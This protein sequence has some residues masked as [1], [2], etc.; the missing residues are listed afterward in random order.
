MVGAPLGI[1]GLGLI[2]TSLARRC[3]FGWN[4]NVLYHDVRRNEQAESELNAACVDV[5]TLLARRDFV[6]VHTDLNPTTRGLFTLAT[7]RKMK[8]TAVFVNAARGPVVVEKDL[9]EA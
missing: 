1:P 2:A 8:P 5:D 4:M 3:R 6:S 7:F 9:I